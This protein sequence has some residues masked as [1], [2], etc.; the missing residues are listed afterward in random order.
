MDNEETARYIRTLF[1]RRGSGGLRKLALI[2]FD[3]EKQH[4][5]LSEFYKGINGL[6]NS[7]SNKKRLFIQDR[8]SNYHNGLPENLSDKKSLAKQNKIDE[9]N[10]SLLNKNR[11][12]K[13]KDILDIL[14]NGKLTKEQMIILIKHE[15]E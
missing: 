2:L 7:L 12:P 5:A 3:N 13:N 15:L 11:H 9:Y 10:N 6:P 4:T 8:I 14:N 1:K